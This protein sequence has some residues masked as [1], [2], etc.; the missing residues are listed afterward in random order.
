[1]LPLINYP[2][3]HKTKMF[4]N[5]GNE[6]IKISSK[7]HIVKTK[8]SD[9]FWILGLGSGVCVCVRGDIQSSGNSL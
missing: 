8:S 9:I 7:V 4:R 5:S 1:M 6:S 2:P 3:G